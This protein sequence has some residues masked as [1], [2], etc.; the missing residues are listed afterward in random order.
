MLNDIKS[1]E[2]MR[3]KMEKQLANLDFLKR[4]RDN[5][6]IP[7]F[8]VIRKKLREQNQ[9]IMSK[10]TTMITRSKFKRTCRMIE[11]L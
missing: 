10:V 11:E 8:I 6:I 1:I 3:E 2:K 9:R 4:C 5:N 7:K